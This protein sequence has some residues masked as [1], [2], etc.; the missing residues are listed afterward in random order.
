MQGADY[1]IVLV[2][3][4][5]LVLGF[6][7]GFVREAVLLLAWLAGIWCAWHYSYLVHPYLGGLLAEPGVQEWAGRIVVLFLVL[8]TGAALASVIAYATHKAVG[9][10]F[11]DRLLGAAFGF[12]RGVIIV[13]LAITAGRALQLDGESWWK[14]SKLMPLAGDVANVLQRYAEPEVKRLIKEAADAAEQ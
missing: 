3:S 4:I 10:E 8:L 1:V 9:L 6:I 14:R 11:M 13:A 5:S 12:V 2:L 7:R